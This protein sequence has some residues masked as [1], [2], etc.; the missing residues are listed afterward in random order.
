MNRDVYIVLIVNS[1][2]VLTLLESGCP[3]HSRWTRNPVHFRE[4]EEEPTF[5]FSHNTLIK[6][7]KRTFSISFFRVCADDIEMIFYLNLCIYM[8]KS[9]VVFRKSFLVLLRF[10]V[11]NAKNN[12]FED[13]CFI[14]LKCRRLQTGLA[15]LKNIKHF[16][17]FKRQ[18]F[19]AIFK[20]RIF[21]RFLKII[22]STRKN[23]CMRLILCHHGR[24]KP[25]KLD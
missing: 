8:D 9:L 20:N 1:W 2:I 3:T 25:T 5:F 19:N 11:K 24:Q 7:Y 18:I 15:I 13:K 4:E 10:L 6:S 17:F 22:S 23:H 12:I 16:I 21:L 14:K